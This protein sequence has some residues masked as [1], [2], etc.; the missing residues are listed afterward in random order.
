[1]DLTKW[2]KKIMNRMRWYDLSLVK[3]TVFFITLFLITAFDGFRNFILEF[4]WYWY[5]L[6][7]IILMILLFKR[8]FKN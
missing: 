2:L 7:A 4:G 5:L 6:I 3:I 8:M 1:M